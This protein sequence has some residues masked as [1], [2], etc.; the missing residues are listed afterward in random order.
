M[1]DRI[2]ECAADSADRVFIYYGDRRYTYAEVNAKANQY[3]RALQSLG[4]KCGD[5]CAMAVENRPEFFFVLW[6]MA[7]LGVT[8]SLINTN[9][10]GKALAHCLSIT[11][12][13]AALVG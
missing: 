7:K 6:A 13:K 2:E 8:A 11:S 1:A 9:I 3:A 4:L 10:T 5:A 12:A